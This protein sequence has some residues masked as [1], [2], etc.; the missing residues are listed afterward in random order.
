MTPTKP[1]PSF[2]TVDARIEICR[3]IPRS[4][5]DRFADFKFLAVN[6]SQKQ[7]VDADNDILGLAQRVSASHQEDHIFIAPRGRPQKRGY[8]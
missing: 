7:I 8:R 1:V 2:L 6:V 3:Q 4:N 5:W